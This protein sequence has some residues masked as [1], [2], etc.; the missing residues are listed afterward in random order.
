MARAAQTVGFSVTPELVS[1][2]QAVSDYFADGNRSAFLRMAVQDY[3]SRMRHAQMQGFRAD[4][5]R[6]IGDVLTEDDVRAL[7]ADTIAHG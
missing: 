7:V 2:I 3:R 5:R 4:A 1:D 6:Q